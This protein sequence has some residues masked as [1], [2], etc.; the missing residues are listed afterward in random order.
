[1]TVA[2]SDYGIYQPVWD[3]ILAHPDLELKLV[4]GAAHL[5]ERYG[6]TVRDIERDGYPIAARVPMLEG[7]DEPINIA[8]ASGRGTMG[9]AEAFANIQPDIILLLGDRYEM[10]AAAVAAVP[11][12]TPIAH[13]HG[14]EETTGAIDNSYRNA[15][16]KM[17]HL[18]YV[19]N[20]LHAQRVIQMGEDPANVVISGAPAIDRLLTMEHPSREEIEQRLGHSLPEKFLIGTF[21]PVTTEYGQATEQARTFLEAVLASGLPTV[22][23]MPNADTGGSAVRAEIAK[24]AG[25]PNL[26]VH[27]NLGARFYPAVMNLATAMIGNSSSGIIEAA[28]LHLPVINIGNRQEGRAQSGNVINVAC[29]KDMIL[30]AIKKATS[31]EFR[32]HVCTVQNVYGSGD[33]GKV[34]ADHIARVELGVRLVKK[35][36]H[37]YPGIQTGIS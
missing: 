23:T 10:H 17:S 14:G 9:F 34:I 35:A 33:A 30:N 24:H 3:A 15:I 6:L 18:H 29:D 5:E 19:S 36:F 32:Q 21:H 26:M 16:T 25:N 1:V 27:E 4:V 37:D 20:E 8:R 11:F 13:L 31:D 12:L 7:G 2:R 28:S 22:L